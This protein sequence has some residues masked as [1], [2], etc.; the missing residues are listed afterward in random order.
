MPNGQWVCVWKGFKVRGLR[1][2]RNLPPQQFLQWSKAVLCVAGIPFTPKFLSEQHP[3]W[4]TQGTDSSLLWPFSW[5][6]WGMVK[7]AGD[8]DSMLRFL[9]SVVSLW[10]QPS[11]RWAY[12]IISKCTEWNS[13]CHLSSL[14]WSNTSSIFLGWAVKSL[15]CHGWELLS[16]LG[17]I[18]TQGL[19]TLTFL[20]EGLYIPEAVITQ[21]RNRSHAQGG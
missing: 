16:C 11:I 19:L 14:G 3:Q 7:A 8:E 21:E 18:L 4:E 20:K 9:S 17:Q 13:C 5:C 2:P 12:V 15:I 6:K 1:K 10:V